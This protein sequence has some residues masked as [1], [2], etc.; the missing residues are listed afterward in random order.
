MNFSESN[1]DR[2]FIDKDIS[3]GYRAFF[4]M[5]LLKAFFAICVIAI[6]AN[7]LNGVTNENALSA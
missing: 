5:D 2:N 4:L 6:H 3:E 1:T 7:S